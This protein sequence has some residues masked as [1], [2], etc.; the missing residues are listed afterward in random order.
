MQATVGKNDSWRLR[1]SAY[2][3]AKFTESNPQILQPV[4]DTFGVDLKDRLY[5]EKYLEGL[6]YA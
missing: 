3:R 5:N 2:E 6:Y 4:A 1:S